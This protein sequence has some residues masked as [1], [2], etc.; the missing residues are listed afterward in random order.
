MR[1]RLLGGRSNAGGVYGKD[2]L[3]FRQR[4]AEGLWENLWL[5]QN[6]EVGGDMSNTQFPYSYVPRHRV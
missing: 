2:P 3:S 4:R 6:W 5:T 1:E